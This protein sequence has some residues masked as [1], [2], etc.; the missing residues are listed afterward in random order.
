MNVNVETDYSLP[1]E[2]WFLGN[3]ICNSTEFSF[4]KT[5]GLKKDI[6]D[7]P[8]AYYITINFGIIGAI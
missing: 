4:L 6:G 5:S 3:P 8:I 1:N 2:A 7:E